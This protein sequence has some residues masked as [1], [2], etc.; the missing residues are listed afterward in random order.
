MDGKMPA[1]EIGIRSSLPAALHPISDQPSRSMLSCDTGLV[2]LVFVIVGYGCRAAE[3]CRS[4]ALA[5]RPAAMQAVITDFGARGDGKT[6]NT[7]SV[8]AAI[9]RV[10]SGGGGTVVIPQGVFPSGA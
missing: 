8:Q 7:S 5:S 6:L 2:L 3:G 1:D 10:A 4:G 9:D